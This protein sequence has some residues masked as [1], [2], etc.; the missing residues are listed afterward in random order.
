[1]VVIMEPSRL[2]FPCLSG[3]FRYMDDGL[4][5]YVRREQ[6]GKRSNESGQSTCDWWLV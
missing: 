3:E 4:E 6:I 1:M 2:V 5:F